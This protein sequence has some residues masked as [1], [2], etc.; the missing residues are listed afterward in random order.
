MFSNSSDL[1]VL[2]L[3]HNYFSGSISKWLGSSLEI[4]TLHLKGNH[5]QGTIPTEICRASKL[6]IM[7]LSHNNL[8]GPIPHCI[9]NMMQLTGAKEAYPYGPS[10]YFPLTMHGFGANFTTKHNTYS[11]EGCVVDSMAGIDLSNNQ[12]SCEIPRELCNLTAMQAL[13]LSSND[14]IGTILF[15]F[16]NLQKIESL[17]LSYNKLSG[18]IPSQLVELTT[19][20]VFSVAHNNLIGMAPKRT[21]Q[22]ATFTE[23]SYEGKPFLCGPLLHKNCMESKEIP[24]SPPVPDFCED[25]HGFLEMNSFYISFLLAYENVVLA[26]VVVVCVNPYWRNIWFYYVESYMYSCYDY[27]SS[28]Y[29]R[30]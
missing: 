27:F 24:M 21:S 13:N 3:G 14:I 23:S 26:L 2:D 7:D 28:K 17:D 18:R 22:F 30:P 16:L 25:D 20:A 5:L 11:Y 15:E 29:I 12:L 8:S 19:L 9:G 10:F 6:R 1:K 4:T